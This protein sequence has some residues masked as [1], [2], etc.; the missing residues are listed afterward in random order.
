MTPLR[1]QLFH[2]FIF[3]KILT[4]PILAQELS[5]HIFLQSPEFYPV[6][7][8]S[9]WRCCVSPSN[10]TQ[11]DAALS[12]YMRCTHSLHTAARQFALQSAPPFNTPL[13]TATNRPAAV[14]QIVVRL[15][16]AV[17]TYLLQNVWSDLLRGPLN[18]YREFVPGIKRPGRQPDHSRRQVPTL[19]MNITNRQSPLCL[20]VALGASLPCEQTVNITTQHNTTQHNTTQSPV[21]LL[22]LLLVFSPWAGLGRDQSSV[23]RL[24][25]LWYA[26]SWASS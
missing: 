8:Y 16:A 12:H 21:L 14:R 13:G 4:K 2:S 26:A 17:N 22:L 6:Q 1:T 20:F 18:G 11:T 3:S 15:P 9:I 19:W 23:R 25:W 10:T 7:H 24:V 5:K